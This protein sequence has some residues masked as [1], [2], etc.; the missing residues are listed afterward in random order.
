[1]CVYKVKG[2]S[3]VMYV[4]PPIT[5]VKCEARQAT[6]TSTPIDLLSGKLDQQR[7]SP[8]EQL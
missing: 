4:Y 2:D 5:S 3:T 6:S 7:N 8:L 1:M